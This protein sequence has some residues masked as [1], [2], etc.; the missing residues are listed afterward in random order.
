MT[1]HYPKEVL[2]EGEDEDDW[3]EISIPETYETVIKNDKLVTKEL[4]GCD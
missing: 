1:V 3:W 4:E 2:A